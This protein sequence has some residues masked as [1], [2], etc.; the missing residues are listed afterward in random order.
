LD[1]SLVETA[2]FMGSNGDSLQARGTGQIAEKRTP[3][4]FTL[5]R[6]ISLTT[7][8]TSNTFE[9]YILIL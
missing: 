4:M 9:G 1:L 5:N 8:A 7:G 6:L 2:Q 3:G